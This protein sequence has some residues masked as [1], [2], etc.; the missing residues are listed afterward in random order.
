MQISR[1]YSTVIGMFFG[2][3]KLGKGS[4]AQVS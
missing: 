3:M 1:L 2:M 4:A